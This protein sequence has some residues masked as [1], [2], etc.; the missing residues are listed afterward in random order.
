MSRHLQ[1][2]WTAAFVYGLVAPSQPLNAQEDRVVQE[3]VRFVAAGRPTSR[4]GDARK[5]PVLQRRVTLGAAEHTL[6][7]ALRAITRQA[8]LE[9]SYSPSIVPLE[10]HATVRAESLT[11]GEALSQLLAGLEVDVSVT[12]SGGLALIRR[13]APTAAA[14]DSGGVAGRVI[15][16]QTS[17]PLPGASITVSGVATIASADTRGEFQVRGLAPGEYTVRARYI[18]YTPL[19]LTVR[20]SADEVSLLTF[21]LERSAHELDQVVVTGTLIPT[22]VKA[23]PSPVTLVDEREIAAQRPQNIQELFRKSVPGAVSWSPSHATY[24]TDFSVRGASSLV[25]TTASMKVLIDGVEAAN[26]TLSQVDPASIARVEIVRGPQA[27]AIYGS[28]AIGGVIQIFTKRGSEEL[29]RPVVDLEASVGLAQTPYGEFREVPRQEYRASIRG[30]ALGGGY[31]VGAGYTHLA[32][33]LPPA[34]EISR[35]STPSLYGGMHVSRGILAVSISGRFLDQR[36][37]NNL[38]N[39]EILDAGFIP[40]SKPYYQP[41]RSQNVTVGAQIAATPREWWRT[42]L[43]LGVDRRSV[44]IAQ[45][46]PRLTT[47]AD[48]LLQVTDRAETKP[49][50]SLA[51]AVEGALSR[52]LSASGTV[53][54]DHWSYTAAGYTTFDAVSTGSP[55]RLIPG[56]LVFA[57]RSVTRNTGVF[58]QVQAGFREALFVTAGLR[59]ERNT[60]FG[61]SLGTPLLPRLGVTYVHSVGRATAKA[62]AS[63][64][65]AINPP[66]SG[67]KA[68]FKSAFRDQLPNPLLGPE[69]QRGWDAG[70]DLT[71]GT[72]AAF[73]FTYYD[74]V[75]EDLIDL[76]VS[77]GTVPTQ[78]FQNV[79][80]VRNTGIELEGVVHAGPVSLQ[81]QYGYSRARVERLSP[82][83]GGA[84]LVGDQVPLRPRH[85]FGLSASASPNRGTTVSAGAAYLGSWT[86]T[87]YLALIRCLG[88][89]GPCQATERGFLVRFPA[90]QKINA[91]VVQQLTK[92]VAGFV[93]VDNLTNNTKHEVDNTGPVM[94][95]TTS[96]GV[97]L[98]Y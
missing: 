27:A 74:Q 95:R 16:R 35:Q 85:T 13:I 64:G 57:D 19:T 76:V 38:S 50:I 61:D 23:L 41:H 44:D 3:R 5:A 39:P 2:F 32:S 72:R 49:S 31:Q 97:R 80:Q 79:G 37:G 67:A 20:V 73:G 42:T 10:M 15:D 28:E 22:E 58:A 54:V 25:P 86:N 11:V 62:R 51:T 48:T 77:Q 89:T 12:S 96:V 30:G 87:D 14:P 24:G 88:G 46:R 65:R 8:D 78:Q 75:A 7:S 9:I 81:G 21:A 84:L 6:G 66:S 59:A 26:A 4:A 45:E 36:G 40:Y 18:G 56:A 69:R 71:F 63:W 52:S 55:V 60:D 70:V 34:G 82:S 29:D 47:P 33:W 83:Y 68:G 17:N 53:G 98:E 90:L 93:N 1:I 91:N 94:G 43:K 92:T